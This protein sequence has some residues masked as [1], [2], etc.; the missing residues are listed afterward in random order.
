MRTPFPSPRRILAPL[1]AVLSPL[2]GLSVGVAEAQVDVWHVGTGGIPWAAAAD[3]QTGALEIGG[4]LQPVELGEGQNLVQLLRTS[5]QVWL[6]G[7]PRDFIAGG[8]PRAWS[9]D[10]LFNQINGPLLLVDG[11]PETHSKGVFKSARSQAGALFSWDLGA[12]Y[13][14]D[15]IRFYPAADDPDAFIKAFEIRINDGQDFNDINRPNYEL[16]RRVEVNK[17][18]VVDL[19]FA[20]L[21]GRFLQLKVLSKTVFNLAEFEIYGEGLVPV[22]SYV[23]Q[24]HSFG[25]PVNFDK[26]RIHSTRLGSDLL[27]GSEPPTA[28]VQL[29]TGADETPLAYFRRNRDTG[30]QDEVSHAEYTA[31]LPRRAL[32]R[33]DA[34]TGELLEEVDRVTYLDLPLAEQG[35]VRDYDQGDV[36]EDVFNWSPWSPPLAIDSTGTVEVSVNLPSPREYMQFRVAFQG[37]PGNAMRLERLEVEYSPRL[38][39]AAVGEVALASEPN[40]ASGVLEVEGGIDTTFTYDIR[41]EFDAAGLDGYR[42]IRVEAFPPPIFER[43]EMGDPLAEVTGIEAAATDGGFDILFAPVA[44]QN[45]Q[46]LRVT[47]RMRVLEHN[48]P[49]YA[50]LLG[51][52]GVPPHPVAAG[53][54][55]DEVGTGSI[56]VYSLEAEPAVGVSLT[57]SV[58]TPNG[59]GINDAASLSMILTQ[60][61]SGIEISVEVFDLGGRRVR[62]LVSV[63]RSAGAYTDFWDGLDDGHNPVPPGMYLCRIAAASD[64]RNIVDVKLI[65]VVY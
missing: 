48:T 26:L 63:A 38:V 1:L 34:A 2:C 57:P 49:V 51:E 65:G 62:Q 42:G 24:L 41:T 27:G 50:W 47:F 14:I 18:S 19:S 56:N 9:N 31:D 4:G 13:P 28:T 16:L 12:P 8:Q 11:D 29:R 7:Q 21:Q 10:G 33:Q 22:A 23:S 3:N 32:Y 64:S 45:N 35:P 6:N 15:R 52:G 60:F 37:D 53:N 39:S 17:E 20:P 44:R 40:P 25:A 5:G 55:N 59:D 30:S 54:A 46:P 61:T 58:I 43:L 36:R